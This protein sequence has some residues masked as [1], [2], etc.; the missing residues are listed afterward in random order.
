[1]K[2]IDVQHLQKGDYLSPT[3]IEEITG[4]MEGTREYQF[5]LMQLRQEIEHGL[6]CLGRPATIKTEGSGLRCS[7]TLRR[8]CT[9]LATATWPASS[10]SAPSAQPG[11][12]RG[13]LIESRTAGP[14][15]HAGGPRQVRPSP[16]ADQPATQRGAGPAHDAGTQDGG[17]PR[18]RWVSGV[19]TQ[20]K[21]RFAG[22]DGEILV[23]ARTVSHRLATGSLRHP[24]VAALSGD[25]KGLG[26]SHRR[27]TAAD[28]GLRESETAVVQNLRNRE[29]E[30]EKHQ[31][32]WAKVCEATGIRALRELFGGKLPSGLPLWTRKNIDR[33]LY[34]ILMDNR[35]LKYREEDDESCSSPDDVTAT[36]P[37]SASPADVPLAIPI[38]A[39]PATETA[40][41]PVR[42]AAKAPEKPAGKRT[43]KSSKRTGKRKRTTTGSSAA[44][45][46]HSSGSR[47]SKSKHSEN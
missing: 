39:S 2:T 15:P 14:L 4:E 40:V 31:R 35:P 42:A 17:Q 27:R 46:K 30:C 20:T 9:T 1:M 3:E 6:R 19:P 23:L 36:L 43:R 18:L 11:G 5:A 44:A 28:V 33:R 13:Q 37:T 8:P 24:G 32:L 21:A 10:C 41:P 22:H 29:E 47:K 7:P 26:P 12:R 45:R 16:Q 25:R 38:L 34:A